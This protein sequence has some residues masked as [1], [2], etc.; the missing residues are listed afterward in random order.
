MC[1]FILFTL[2]LRLQSDHPGKCGVRGKQENPPT[3]RKPGSASR[4]YH[5]IHPCSTSP[6]HYP[7]RR[8]VYHII[9]YLSLSLS[10]LPNTTRGGL[11]AAGG[12]DYGY[13]KKNPRFPRFFPTCFLFCQPPCSCSL[14]NAN[15]SLPFFFL[16]SFSFSPPAQP[17]LPCEPVDT[18][19]RI[20]WCR[21]LGI[22]TTGGSRLSI[23]T[24]IHTGVYTGGL[25]LEEQ[26][27]H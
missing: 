1:F 21:S 15:P 13:I 4:L 11:N 18:Y 26:E 25:G 12:G 6:L 17:L 5:S 24:Y 22:P 9:S 2:A 8:Q 19:R 14:L 7:T 20:Y 23:L 16:F 27:Y 10:L 3:N